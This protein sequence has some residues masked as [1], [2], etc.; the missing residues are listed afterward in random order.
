MY[1][2]VDA[3]KIDLLSLG[4]MSSVLFTKEPGTAAGLVVMDLAALR[5]PPLPETSSGQQI[6]ALSWPNKNRE[7]RAGHD[8]EL[9]R[10][11]GLAPAAIQF[12][13][14]AMPPVQSASWGCRSAERT[15]RL[16]SQFVIIYMSKPA[17]IS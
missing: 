5:P 3:K 1:T 15:I 17:D 8:W 11:A 10:C 2:I 4:D 13:K 12:R 6:P 7:A 9:T 16:Q 14:A